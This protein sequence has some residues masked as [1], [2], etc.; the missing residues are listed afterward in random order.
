MINIKWKKPSSINTVLPLLI[1][2]FSA[3]PPWCWTGHPPAAL[4]LLAEGV[5]FT[6]PSP[7]IGGGSTIS[8][9]VPG[10][11]WWR[12]VNIHTSHLATTGHWHHPTLATTPHWS[13][14]LHIITS[15]SSRSKLLL[16]MFIFNIMQETN[17]LNLIKYIMI[18]KH[19]LKLHRRLSCYWILQIHER[20]VG[21]CP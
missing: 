1:S 4:L 16:T 15:S 7:P 21:L 18:T 20:M 5:T 3:A 11:D 17:G 19:S 9:L 14:T 6:P 8:H 10:C 13:C 2:V 12:G